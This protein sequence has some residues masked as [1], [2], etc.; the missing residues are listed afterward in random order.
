MAGNQTVAMLIVGALGVGAVQGGIIEVPQSSLTLIVIAGIGIFSLVALRELDE[1]TTARWAA[2]LAAT[3]LVAVQTL[4]DESL[5][6][7]IVNSEV[8]PILAIAGVYLAYKLIQGIR[9]SGKEP[10][11]NIVIQSDSTQQNDGDNQ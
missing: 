11:T 3:T 2:I 5:V 4:S 9:Q 7:A 6:T 10:P 1:F 8:W